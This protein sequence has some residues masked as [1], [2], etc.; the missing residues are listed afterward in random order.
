MAESVV[1]PAPVSRIRYGASDA[2]R[3]ALLRMTPR[4]RDG[5]SRTCISRRDRH[6]AD[7]S[8]ASASAQEPIR[9]IKITRANC[10]LNALQKRCHRVSD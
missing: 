10:G 2:L 6:L 4:P 5:L 8:V 3:G 9:P 1:G 7:A